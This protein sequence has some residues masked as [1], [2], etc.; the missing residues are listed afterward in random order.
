MQM[1]K[2]DGCFNAKD[3]SY[4]VSVVK[5]NHAQDGAAE[6]VLVAINPFWQQFFCTN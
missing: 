3:L 5:V 6:S 2:K 4:V 1:I